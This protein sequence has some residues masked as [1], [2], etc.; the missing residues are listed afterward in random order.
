[1]EFRPS[2]TATVSPVAAPSTLSVRAAEGTLFT[3]AISVLISTLSMVCGAGS[4]GGA[5]VFR[6]VRS[7]SAYCGSWHRGS[8]VRRWGAGGDL[9]AR[10][11]DSGDNLLA[12]S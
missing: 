2:M 4:A 7:P 9:T 1:M 11:Q 5:G 8:D 12:D 6:E 3:V 10:S